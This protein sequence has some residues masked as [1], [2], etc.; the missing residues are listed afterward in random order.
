LFGEDS[1]AIAAPI[2]EFALATV[3]AGA[4]RR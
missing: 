3:G 1:E 2:L 4:E